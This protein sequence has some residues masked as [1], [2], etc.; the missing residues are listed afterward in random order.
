MTLFYRPWRALWMLIVVAAGYT[1]A[2]FGHPY[3]AVTVTAVGL[4]IDVTMKA[5]K[6]IS[7]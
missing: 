2:H 7:W 4:S 5:T 3:W 6:A 1:L